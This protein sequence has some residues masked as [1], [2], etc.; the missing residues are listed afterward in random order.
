MCFQLQSGEQTI[1]VFVYLTR[2]DQLTQRETRN[3]GACLKAWCEQNLLATMFLLHLPEGARRHD[4]SRST[5]L[6]ENRK[7]FLPPL[8]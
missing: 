8:I 1:G 2:K 3:S 6:V 4:R 5:V 7:F